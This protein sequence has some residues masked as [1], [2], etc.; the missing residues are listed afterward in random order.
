MVHIKWTLWILI[1]VVCTKFVFCF[2][3]ILST[4]QV[5]WDIQTIVDHCTQNFENHRKTIDSNG[6]ALKKHSMV[7][8]VILHLDD[9][10]QCFL[11][12]FQLFGRYISADLVEKAP[13]YF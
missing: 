3:L 7:I 8:C 4:F 11:H 12:L 2:K 13:K 9:K 1:Y 5:Q 6:W 10:Y